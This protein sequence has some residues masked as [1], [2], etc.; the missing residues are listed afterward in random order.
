MWPQGLKV[1]A[2]ALVFHHG[3]ALGVWVLYLMAPYNPRKYPYMMSC[4]LLNFEDL[5]WIT[6]R[7]G[8]SNLWAANLDVLISKWTFSLAHRGPEF[9]GQRLFNGRKT[10]C[11]SFIPAPV[12][13]D[14]FQRRR[15]NDGLYTSDS[16]KNKWCL[17]I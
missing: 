8:V 11:C 4:S 5:Q 1:D 2:W 15:L 10:F 12:L 16:I 13:Q 3:S 6:P 9:P 17:Q 7:N 14:P